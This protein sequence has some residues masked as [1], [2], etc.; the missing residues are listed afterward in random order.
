MRPVMWSLA[1]IAAVGSAAI[2][3]LVPALPMLANDLAV[4]PQVAQNTISLYLL[5]LA[6]GQ[7][8][9]GPMTDRAG[10]RPMLIAGAVLH[11]AGAALGAGATSITVLLFG[12]IIQ[13]IGAGASLVA[14]R[15]VVGDLFS[16]SEG[17]RGQA[18]L[19]VVALIAP[20]IAPAVGGQISD[21]FGWSA[22]LALQAA[23][24]FTALA[25]IWRW[26]PETLQRDEA[27]KGPFAGNYMRLARNAD[28]R[29]TAGSIALYGCALFM[30]F[31]TA[32]FLLIDQWKASAG[33]AGL[34]LMLTAAAAILG[35]LAVAH[36]EKRFDTLR[37][38]LAIS[39]AGA[40]LSMTLAI[41]AEGGWPALIGPAMIVT[42]GLGIAGP[43]GVV[44]ILH[45][46]EGLAG[47]A[48][49]LSGA[50]QMSVGAV[51]ALALSAITAP[52]FVALSIAM[53]VALGLAWLSAPLDRPPLE[54]AR[55]R[56]PFT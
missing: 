30:F 55:P 11:I 56:G 3:M 32:P 41:A 25:V 21:A 33:E 9:A 16:R 44:R 37:L 24:A 19:M 31:A 7:L 50:L 27:G 48:L 20:A 12:R 53:A 2:H 8:V 47:T 52:S 42:F 34:Y 46:E 5:G 6:A 4:S 23:A 28:F 22:I 13:A 49:S 1:L 35:T 54:T 18:Q 43:A 51:A 14:A 36:L 17:G 29:R 40:V 15:V 10:R 39:L 26:V 38:G 45:C